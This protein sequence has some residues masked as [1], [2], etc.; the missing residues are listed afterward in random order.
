MKKLSTL[1]FTGLFSRLVADG[2]PVLHRFG[3]QGQLLQSTQ[4]AAAGAVS[5]TL[6]FGLQESIEIGGVFL[7][8]GAAGVQWLFALEHMRVVQGGLC[9]GVGR[10]AD[11]ARIQREGERVFAAFYA[12]SGWQPVLLQERQQSRLRREQMVEAD[13]QRSAAIS[14]F[15]ALE[16]ERVLLVKIRAGDRDGARGVLNEMLATIYLSA[17]QQAVLRARVIALV[18]SLTRAA[19]EDNPLL[20][21]LILQNQHW[22]G[23][24]AQADSFEELSRV[25]ML[26][27]DA[28][29]DTVHLHGANRTNVH[30]H[31]ALSYILQSYHE[32]LGLQEV[33]RHVGLSGYRLAHLFREHTGRT[34]VETIREVRLQ[35]AEVLLRENTLTCAEV[36]YAVGFSDQ[37]YFSML[38]RKHA[39]ETPG[40]YQRRHQRG[41]C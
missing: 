8:R 1:F 38:F 27:L 22:T 31:R 34:V 13:R 7:C 5:A 36:A 35:R 14:L 32:A 28:F 26:A 33:A 12:S 3:V 30:V 10:D 16:P 21:S 29:L 39:G 2:V 37:S 24:M 17:P 23:L 25:L 19:V 41:A 40:A 20:E 11:A 18:C 6:R 4:R 9:G 15:Q